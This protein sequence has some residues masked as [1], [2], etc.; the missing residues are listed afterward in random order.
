MHSK[1]FLIFIIGISFCGAYSQ[2]YTSF[3]TKQGLPSNH[4]YHSVQDSKG[5]MWFATNRGVA[6]FD[7]K[8]FRV[9]TTKDGL[10]NN[11][12]WKLT[13]DNQGRIWY[14]TKSRYL[15][16]IKNDSV[17][18][19]MATDR[20]VMYTEFWNNGNEIVFIKNES[21]HALKNDSIRVKKEFRYENE[22]RIN[23][24]NK[25]N[26]KGELVYY[27]TDYHSKLNV[28]CSENK[29]F[30]FDSTF[31]NIETHEL[32]CRIPNS[33]TI[34]NSKRGIVLKNSYFF[35]DN[36]G[37]FLYNHKNKKVMFYSSDTL[38]NQKQ[39]NN[40]PFLLTE[41]NTI[42]F[43][44]S[45]YLFILNK[46]FEIMESYSFPDYLS[47][48]NSYKDREGNIWLNNMKEGVVLLPNSIREA[49]VFLP[50][51]QIQKVNRIRGNVVAGE[52][53]VGFYKYET[54]SNKF[55]L[56]N[57]LEVKGNVYQIETIKGLGDIF[58]NFDKVYI[59]NK[60]SLFELTQMS[61]DKLNPD[62]KYPKLAFKSIEFSKD[63]FVHLI[64]NGGLFKCK[65]SKPFFIKY[66]PYQGL[67]VIS[68]F[69]NKIYAGGSDGL[70][71]FQGD[72]LLRHINNKPNSKIP[73]S[74]L[75][76]DDNYLYVGT[77]GRGVYLYDGEKEFHL[78]STDGL[79]I[80]KIIRKED[81]LWLATQQGVKVISL[82]FA[83][84][85]SSSLINSF[86]DSDGL[87]QNNTNDIL[88]EDSMLWVATDIGLSRINTKSDIYTLK[89]PVRFDFKKDTVNFKYSSKKQ[90]AA[91]FHVINYT[92]QEYLGYEYRLL[93]VSTEWL[94]TSSTSLNFSGLSPD[95]YTL[96]VK[97]VDQHNNESYGSQYILILP[98]WWQT[99]RAKAG[100]LLLFGLLLYALFKYIQLRIRKTEMK[101]TKLAGLELQALRSQMNPHFV[102]NSLNAIK[103]YIQR[104]EVEM[105]EEYLT[106]FAQLI[107]LFFDFSRRETVSLKEEINLLSLYLQIEQLRFEEKLN[108]RI[109]IDE[110]LDLEE[111]RLPTMLLQPIIENAVNHGVFHKKG[112]GLVCL[113]IKYISQH[114][115]QV[116]IEDDG[117]GV[118]SAK[119]INV[120]SSKNYKSKSS[121][122]LKDRLELLNKSKRWEVSYAI[123]DLADNNNNQGT[124]V[125]L[126]FNLKE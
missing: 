73:V 19:F 104:N 13:A 27:L 56:L 16:Y 116:I 26:L 79:M 106:K 97:V 76:S 60:D 117:I 37:L 111:S 14:N 53:K 17:Y 35:T 101:K 5:Y 74:Y 25:L 34:T 31:L 15:G 29:A 105:S 103:Y 92:N 28:I 55:G 119:S 52:R 82:D 69:Q 32:N 24:I 83:N 21:I 110:R 33:A 20:S 115:F 59:K 87:I 107:R 7:G 48:K 36:R 85:E 81:E 4:I 84:L 38:I 123:E 6:K 78:K 64:T 122:V 45:G 109:E 86:Y 88:L 62:Q 118:N 112:T 96:E 57:S 80:Q 126:L 120:I 46:N 113:E 108:F 10:P 93:P 89:M 124:R 51:K 43:S 98:A 72:S 66:L 63:G 91:S 54:K 67:V 40:T 94:K 23:A 77:D 71:I 39:F 44:F 95:L 1:L 11:D 114:S 12:I 9:F 30:V 75:K 49:S 8:T 90:I 121:E 3:S 47:N 65:F 61:L 125:S 70:F 22:E 100:F 68:K 18:K 58:L 2:E 99:T 42:Q 41:G 50:E 102:H